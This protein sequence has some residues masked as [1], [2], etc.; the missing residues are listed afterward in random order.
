MMKK[1]VSLLQYLLTLKPLVNDYQLS[2]HN[3]KDELNL[4]MW[5]VEKNLEMKQ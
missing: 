4:N 1:T 5:N 2:N 3:L